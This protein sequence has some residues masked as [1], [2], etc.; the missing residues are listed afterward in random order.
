MLTVMHIAAV[1][2]NGCRH[3]WWKQMPPSSW[4]AAKLMIQGGGVAVNLYYQQQW[5]SY[6]DRL[7]MLLK[8]PRPRRQRKEPMLPDWHKSMP[9]QLLPWDIR[10]SLESERFISRWRSLFLEVKSSTKPVS[11]SVEWGYSLHR[12]VRW[13]PLSLKC[14]KSHETAEAVFSW[15]KRFRE[16]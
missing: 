3:Q 8:V 1:T 4:K 11:L 9:N 16:K 10:N 12:D 5:R 15:R 7:N 14:D 2:V 13:E 6:P